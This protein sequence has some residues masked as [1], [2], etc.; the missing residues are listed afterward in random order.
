VNDILAKLSQNEKLMGVGAIGVA[1]GWILGMVIASKN[2]CEGLDLGGYASLCPSVN[3]FTWGNAGT[4]AILA[5]A[6]AIVLVVVLYLKISSANITWPMPVGQILLGLAVATVALAA[7]TVLIQI[8]NGL[9]G[10]PIG[11]WIADVVFVGG[12]AVAAY[13]AYMEY[14]AAASK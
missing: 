2:A 7:L 5:L 3:F 9:D 4:L 13:G 8:S 14:A 12:A 10:A 6:A 1:L 11:M